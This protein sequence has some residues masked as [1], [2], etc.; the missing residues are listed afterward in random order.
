MGTNHNQLRKRL[1]LYARPDKHQSYA[2]NQQH[3]RNRRRDLR[4]L[5]LVHGG[6]DGAKL[7]DFFLVV[8]AEAGVDQPS[9]TEN[10]KSHSEND[11]K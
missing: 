11:D 5:L 3:N 6:L 10:K 9:H 1:F 7:R 8:I 4:G 2:R